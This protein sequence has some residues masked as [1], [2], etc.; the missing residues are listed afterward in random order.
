MKTYLSCC[1]WPW[2]FLGFMNSTVNFLNSASFDVT[3]KMLLRLILA[4]PSNAGVLIFLYPTDL[5]FE[6]VFFTHFFISPFFKTFF[7]SNSSNLFL[8]IYNFCF[9]LQYFT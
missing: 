1:H 7:P 3:V 5:P 6:K 2:C 4:Y 8:S 9:D